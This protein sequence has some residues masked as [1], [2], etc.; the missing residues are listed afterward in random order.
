MHNFCIDYS[1]NV[2]K[3]RS[4]DLVAIRRSAKHNGG[5]AD[6]VRLDESNRPVSLLNAA[7]GIRA[8][9]GS[10]Q[11]RLATE[12]FSMDEMVKRVERLGLKRPDRGGGRMR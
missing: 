11:S 9:T 10:R 7:E 12:C 8:G 5:A 3:S 6:E 1:E 4:H 2:P